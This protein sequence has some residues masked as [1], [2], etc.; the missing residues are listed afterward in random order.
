MTSIEY[1]ASL[2][3]YFAKQEPS[4]RSGYGIDWRLTYKHTVCKDD[5]NAF[6][7]KKNGM[8]FIWTLDS[9]GNKHKSFNSGKEDN[10]F[11]VRIYMV[12]YNLFNCS[13]CFAREI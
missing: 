10:L 11:I 4:I 5:K 8:L 12:R 7:K 13:I 9:I 3:E 2:V 1:F 6:I